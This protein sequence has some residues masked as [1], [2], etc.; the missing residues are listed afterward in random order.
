MPNPMYVNAPYRVGF[1]IGIP[2]LNLPGNWSRKRRLKAKRR[3]EKRYIEDR[4]KPPPATFT[5]AELANSEPKLILPA[6]IFRAHLERSS[7]IVS[8]W[9]EWKRKILS[10]L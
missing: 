3:Y 7:R 5:A 10:K 6:H 1:C 8:G 2:K 4:I 9:P